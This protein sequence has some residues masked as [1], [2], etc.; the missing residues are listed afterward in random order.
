MFEWIRRALD[1][2]DVK[3]L[4]EVVTL[5]GFSVVIPSQAAVSPT[6]TVQACDSRRML[7]G[8]KKTALFHK[9][10][11]ERRRHFEPFYS[12]WKTEMI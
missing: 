12:E 5:L 6:H 7:E 10:K 8:Q 9:E 3:E 11:S 1:Q 2:L 4:M